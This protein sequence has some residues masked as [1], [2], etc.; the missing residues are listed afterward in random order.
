MRRRIN[1]TPTLFHNSVG[2]AFA[3]YIA[4]IYKREGN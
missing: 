3:E 4:G 1:A 2:V